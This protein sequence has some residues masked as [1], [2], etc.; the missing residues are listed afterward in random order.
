LKRLL[1]NLT[2]MHGGKSRADAGHY[3]QPETIRTPSMRL[4]RWRRVDRRV[5]NAAN[6]FIQPHRGSVDRRFSTHFGH[7]VHGHSMCTLDIGK[8]LIAEKKA[9]SFLSAI[10]TT[11]VWNR[12]GVHRAVGNVENGI[13]IM[14][15]NP[16]EIKN[17]HGLRFNAV[18]RT[19]SNERHE[20]RD[21]R[22]RRLSDQADR[23]VEQ[24][25]EPCQRYA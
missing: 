16:A 20:A 8:R 10:L 15:Q 22:Q 18:R 19:V 17:P 25:D 1:P 3:P 21:C 14:T 11:W 4:G 23:W 6:G 7:C 5:N 9:A 13:N 12:S 2:G 24:S